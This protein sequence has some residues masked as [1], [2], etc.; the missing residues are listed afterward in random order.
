VKR[1]A[2]DLGPLSDIT[3]EADGTRSRLI[4]TR[5]LPHPPEKVWAALTDPARLEEWAPFVAGR[6]LGILGQTT[7]TMI[8]GANLDDMPA[9]VRRAEPPHLL[10]YT[11]GDDLLRWELAATAAGTSLTLRH[12]IDDRSWVPKVAAGWHVCLVVAERML[13]GDPVGVIIGED[14]KGVGWE[15]LRDAYA[16]RLGITAAE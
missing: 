7:L 8:D 13:D 3:V 10:E 15:R 5:R 12:T 1:T 6:N 14:A 4:F 16:E 2:I 9:T 11:W